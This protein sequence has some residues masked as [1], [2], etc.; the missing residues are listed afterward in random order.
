[1]TV[2]CWYNASIL[3]L[4]FPSELDKLISLKENTGQLELE[5]GFN[6]TMLSSQL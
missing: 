4:I 2:V 3:F 6:I 1:M 5:N